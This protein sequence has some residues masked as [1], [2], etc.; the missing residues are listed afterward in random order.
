[1]AHEDRYP[2]K[3]K[4]IAYSFGIHP[5][6]LTCENQET[7]LRRVSEMALLETVIAVGE[8]GFD[9]IKG[10]EMELQRNIFEEQVHIAEKYNKPVIIHCVR[11]WDELLRAHKKLKP[12]IP[13]LVHG[14]RG[15]A[16]L[17]MQLI[18]RG[19][20]LSF[21]FDFI[22]RP[23]ASALIRKLPSERIFFETD[24]AEV[25]IREIYNKVSADFGIA[26]D[27]LKKQIFNNYMKFF[28]PH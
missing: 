21:W 23:E 9:K 15:K 24:G 5:W 7:M 18:S 27:E 16:D 1:M 3:R 20:Y 8:A 14:F 2:V 25:D 26:I 11:S 12:V 10:P 17:A 4:G 28:R 13:W 6:Y 22:V 19:M